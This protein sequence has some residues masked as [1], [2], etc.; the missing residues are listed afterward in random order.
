MIYKFND[1]TGRVEEC[2]E[3]EKFSEIQAA[4]SGCG[5]NSWSTVS[6]SQSGNCPNGHAYFLYTDKCNS[7][8]RT[9]TSGGCAVSNC[10]HKAPSR[11]RC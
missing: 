4:S 10:S 1:I 11:G 8:G 6:H 2:I 7:C 5:S 3:P 9:S